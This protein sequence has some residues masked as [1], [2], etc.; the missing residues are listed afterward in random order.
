MDRLGEEGKD[1]CIESNIDNWKF[2]PAPSQSDIEWKSLAADKEWANIKTYTLLVLLLVVS[3]FLV[4]PL[5]LINN[6]TKI[7]D[8][9]D[10]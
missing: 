7:M 1:F 5:I 6:A 4:T 10:L 8:Q 3:I 2:K 9:M